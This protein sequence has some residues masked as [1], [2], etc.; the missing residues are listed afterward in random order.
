MI[1][2]PVR[3]RSV[4]SLLEQAENLID[5]TGYDELS[6][7]SLSTGDYTCIEKLVTELMSQYNNKGVAVSLPSLRWTL[8]G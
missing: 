6:L 3:E 1:Y 4:K 7:S 2:R 5:S 8:F